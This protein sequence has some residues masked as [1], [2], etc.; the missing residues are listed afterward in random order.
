MSKPTTKINRSVLM[1]ILR[2]KYKDKDKTKCPGKYTIQADCDAGL[3][4]LAQHIAESLDTNTIN[5]IME[6]VALNHEY[7]PS[8][9]SHIDL[10]KSYERYSDIKQDNKQVSTKMFGNIYE[11]LDFFTGKLANI[12]YRNPPDFIKLMTCIN[13][14]PKNTP[15]NPSNPCTTPCYEEYSSKDSKYHNMMNG[16]H[17][18]YTPGW[19]ELGNALQKINSSLA[20]IYALPR[21][22]TC[23]ETGEIWKEEQDQKGFNLKGIKYNEDG[24]CYVPEESDFIFEHTISDKKNKPNGENNIKDINKC[25]QDNFQF[26]IVHLKAEDI[27]KA[28]KYTD[29]GEKSNMHKLTHGRDIVY[30]LCRPSAG[31]TN[32]DTNFDTDLIDIDKTNLERIP[33]NSTKE[34]KCRKEWNKLYQLRKK[35]DS[36]SRIGHKGKWEIASVNDDGTYHVC[37]RP[38]KDGEETID[39]CKGTITSTD[40]NRHIP[41]V[42]QVDTEKEWVQVYESD[43][44]GI[45]P[46]LGMGGGAIHKLNPSKRRSYNLSRYTREELNKIFASEFSNWNSS[47][48]KENHKLHKYCEDKKYITPEML[49]H[50]PTAKIQAGKLYKNIIGISKGHYELIQ[51]GKETMYKYIKHFYDRAKRN[52]DKRQSEEITKPLVIVAG[53]SLGG[54]MAPLCALHI[55]QKYPDMDIHCVTYGGPRV[56]DKRFADHYDSLKISTRRYINVNDIAHLAT[57]AH[58]L[59]SAKEYTEG[60]DG[61]LDKNGE[62][63]KTEFV[64]YNTGP[65]YSDGRHY[66]HVSGG[67][68][69]GNITDQKNRGIEDKKLELSQLSTN[70]GWMQEIPVTCS[71]DNKVLTCKKLDSSSTSIPTPNCVSSSNQHESCLKQL[72][73]IGDC[74]GSC[75]WGIKYGC[76][77]TGDC[78]KVFKY[79]DKYIKAIRD[80]L[81][82]LMSLPTT[83]AFPL[84][85]E[86]NKGHY[87]GLGNLRL[88]SAICHGWFLGIYFTANSEMRALINDEDENQFKEIIEYYTEIIKTSNKN[89]KKIETNNNNTSIN[90]GEETSCENCSTGLKLVNGFFKGFVN[91]AGDV[92]QMVKTSINTC[93]RKCLIKLL[94]ESNQIGTQ[95]KN[96]PKHLIEAKFN[97][98]DW[99][100]NSYLYSISGIP[101]HFD[102][103]TGRVCQKGIQ[104][105]TSMSQ[106]NMSGSGI[107]GKRYRTKKNKK[108]TKKHIKLRRMRTKNN[109]RKYSKLSKKIR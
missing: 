97:I 67:P 34:A 70:R 82:L 66:C 39:R 79:L 16:Q 11:E 29:E 91:C 61:T 31:Y 54:T 56:G 90:Q 86:P 9:E 27:D 18:K 15:S 78:N 96:L 69:F 88:T 51:S 105:E 12:S 6:N 48:T 32:W 59:T 100:R 63:H 104:I 50:G 20:A 49:G 62:Y 47:V 43:I 85:K 80:P 3:P 2:D 30:M 108:N 94:E 10:D 37:P 109:K 84:P 81:T 107:C 5:T 41:K 106:S 68:Y 92:C 101:S 52:H 103:D 21:I 71:V 13:H 38:F 76:Y 89:L 7:F 4:C 33:I 95:L 1:Q 26:Y 77:P 53:M 64:E 93:K 22:M 23:E 57:P 60:W 58:Y 75:K 24:T 46:S 28:F 19:S 45:A 98:H 55:K 73:Y 72:S 17:G 8:Y 14:F 74:E 35:G 65:D 36:I 42:E 102:D 83:A 40:W 99:T 87:K 44:S 25:E